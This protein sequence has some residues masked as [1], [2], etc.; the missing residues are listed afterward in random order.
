MRGGGISQKVD[1]S[2]YGKFAA[3]VKDADKEVQK[4]FRKAFR[5][6]ARPLGQSVVRSGSASMPSRGGLRARLA[7]SKVGV[8]ASF[9]RDPKVTLR[10]GAKPSIGLKT[11][12][13]GQVRH[14]VWKTGVWVSQRVPSGTYDQAFQAAGPLA[15]R[16]MAA[17]TEDVLNDIGRKT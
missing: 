11:L 7:S 6:I 13:S 2:D 3:S 9:G 12:N 16:R 15:Q 17:A 4:A 14:P 10:L 1:S 5:E 8:A